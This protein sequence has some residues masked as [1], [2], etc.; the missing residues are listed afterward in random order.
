MATADDDAPAPTRRIPIAIFDL[1]AGA[2]DEARAELTSALRGAELTPIAGELGVAFTGRELDEQA[3]AAT[4]AEAQAAYGE[5]DCG[6]AR[7]SA[8]HAVLLLSARV[9]AGADE[10]ARLGK[11]WAYVALCAEHDG[12]RSSASFAVERLRALGFGPGR[13]GP[14]PADAWSRY[15]EIDA[16][17]DRDIVELTV[18][19]PAGAA[20]FVDDRAIGPVPA[21]TFVA[22]GKHVVAIAR[23]ETRGAVL[24]TA[25][26]KPLTVAVEGFDAAGPVAVAAAVRSWQAAGAAEPSAL[27]D[28]MK[29]ARAELAVVIG[30]DGAAALWQRTGATA[31]AI[32][33]GSGPALAEAA[34]EAWAAAHDRAPADGVPLLREGDV[35][36]PRKAEEDAEKAPARWWVYAAIGGAIA[37][38]AVVI[39]AADAGDDRQRFELRF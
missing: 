4:L 36:D 11:A 3:A 30:P 9:A 23:G 14:L 37:V 15:P 20:A 12:D 26:G 18:T 10:Q 31:T 1:R 35:P 33:H 5:L 21:T 2:D 6:R 38:G 17:T 19:G 25:F 34:V 7:P 28:L 16:S 29:Q 32:A 24:T 22:A 39:Y 13:P 27:V 8:E